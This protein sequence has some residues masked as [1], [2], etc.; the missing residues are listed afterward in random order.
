MYAHQPLKVSTKYLRCV[1][2]E[3]YITHIRVN[4]DEEYPT[5]PAPLSQ[6]AS[7]KKPRVI[8][9]AVRKSG[10]V[11][12]HK[13][14]ENAN[15]TFSIGKTWP[16]DDLCR[17]E[18]FTNMAPRSAEQAEN[19]ERAQD[20]GF[21]V[22]MQK[23]Y[24]WQAATAKEK[25]FFIFSLIKI[26]R[27]YT[28]GKL[29][30]LEG[31]NAQELDQLGGPATAVNSP[32]QPRP[33]Q[34]GAPL[35]PL[36]RARAPSQDPPPRARPPDLRPSD[37]PQMTP[38]T[39]RHPPETP[40]DTSFGIRRRPSQDSQNS[41]GQPHERTL[42]S[43]QNSE[44][45]LLHSA[46]S[47]DRNLKHGVSNE[48]MKLPGAFPSSESVPTQG[49]PSHR[50]K[51]SESPGSQRTIATSATGNSRAPSENR[52]GP[53]SGHEPSQLGQQ[54]PPSGRSSSEQPRI[55]GYGAESR[56][57]GGAQQR[58][59]GTDE[60][61]RTATK[62]S[63]VPPALSIRSPKH[64]R[65][66]VSNETTSRSERGDINLP[67]SLRSTESRNG[68]FRSESRQTAQSDQD[69]TSTGVS[70]FVKNRSS[71]PGS[72]DTTER[73]PQSRFEVPAISKED[74]AVPKPTEPDSFS[75]FPP[76][77][78]HADPEPKAQVEEEAHRPG[79]GP[80][81]KKKGNKEI[82]SKFRKAATAYNAFK[83]KATGDSST[84]S[85]T[86][87]PTG[88]GITG[89]FMA[90]SLLRNNTEDS[91]RPKTPTIK[92]DS[93]P[94][95]PDAKRDVPLVDP[96]FSPPKQV[97]LSAP[98]T[99]K[100]QEPV[101]AAVPKDALALSGPD[102]KPAAPPVPA[103]DER[104]KKRRSDHSAKYA[105]SLGIGPGILEGRTLEIEAVLSDFGWGEEDSKTTF[106]ELES[107]IRRELARV[108]AGS[109]LGAVDSSD[110][111]TGALGD[112]M[113]KVLA[114]CEELDCLLTLYNV[115]LGVSRSPPL[116]GSH[117]LTKAVFERRCR[118]HRS[119]VAR[120]AGPNG[121]PEIA[122]H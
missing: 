33:Q 46:G 45:R 31:F 21:I 122:A 97:T 72:R 85:P 18:S 95:T 86:G 91:I 77:E 80:M 70:S 103:Q 43:A 63:D 22:T 13:G 51:R 11:R 111:R 90:P 41:Q 55:N 28:N 23:P 1:A 2:N 76:P 65:P 49:F 100:L 54:L 26:F 20:T 50:S 25:D 6:L 52:Y 67:P 96:T 47:R 15:G 68:S 110:D 89:V 119:P 98:D 62:D 16:L 35:M 39:P 105:K 64:R 32:P 34:N 121:Q 120:S 27:K 69:S 56:M 60:R 102:V 116:R 71:K 57:R 58:S 5:S 48:R 94:S 79:L 115:E 101:S 112:M 66:S 17:I 113:D 24:Y 108:E 10:R 84:T 107:G 19:K 109:W 8:M 106:E 75:S 44:H 99:S 59:D 37:A 73:P 61:P 82:A 83:P 92:V 42:H 40:R 74:I 78:Q 93:R 36:S 38:D 114:E 14:R 53:P 12:M 9:V 29:P 4:E 118:L 30:E 88:D 81:I 7:K 87:E 3:S 117:V 104:R